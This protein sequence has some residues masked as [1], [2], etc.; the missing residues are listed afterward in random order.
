M[1]MCGMPGTCMNS[2]SGSTDVA[3][4]AAVYSSR[5][6]SQFSLHFNGAFGLHPP[7]VSDVGSLTFSSWKS[8][9]SL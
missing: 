1:T 9:R 3:E 4:S 7:T 8:R 6:I 2:D 5:A